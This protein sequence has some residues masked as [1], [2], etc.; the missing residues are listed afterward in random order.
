MTYDGNE[1]AGEFLW[2]EFLYPK[3]ILFFRRPISFSATDFHDVNEDDV[4]K[5]K[6]SQ[7]VWGH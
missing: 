7:Q 4:E 5:I 6:I 1:M 2:D 3:L